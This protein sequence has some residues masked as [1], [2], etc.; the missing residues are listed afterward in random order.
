MIKRSVLVLGSLGLAACNGSSSPSPASDPWTIRYSPGMP[1]APTPNAS[2]GFAFEIPLGGSCPAAPTTPP[3][4]N[5][6]AC[7]HVDYVTRTP[8]PL[9]GTLTLDFTISGDNP[10]FGILTTAT[11]NCSTP[12]SVSLLLEHTNDAAL[13]VMSYRWWAIKDAPIVLGH[14]VLTVP[15]TFANW[16]DTSGPPPG[17]AAEFADALANLGA[18]GMTFGGGCARGHGLYLNSGSATF[19]IN[20]FTSP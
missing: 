17:T 12:P 14:N 1:T 4:F 19:T 8:M 5:V 20:S 16:A 11:N 18:V 3:D 2:G 7:H 13:N 9:S 10:S 15:L 6:S